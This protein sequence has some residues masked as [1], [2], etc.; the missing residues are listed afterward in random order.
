MQKTN[1]QTIV[2]RGY[3]E[4]DG[5][6]SYRECKQVGDPANIKSMLLMDGLRWINTIS[7]NPM[8]LVN[9]MEYGIDMHEQNFL[10]FYNKDGDEILMVKEILK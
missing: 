7:L 3:F 4:I 1:R 2:T 8:A 10:C 6:Q 9:R 5:E